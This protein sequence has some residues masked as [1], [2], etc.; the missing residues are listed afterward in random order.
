MDTASTTN[1]PHRRLRSKSFQKNLLL[2][3]GGIFLL[4]A[5][6][7][8]VYQYQRE[9]AYKIDILH[10]RLQMFNYEMVQTLGDSITNQPLFRDY[11]NLHK[12]E[13]LR[14]T[15]INNEG[16]VLLDSYETN[17]DSLSNHLGRTEIQG[18]LRDGNGYDIKRTSESTHE[19]YFYS[20]TKFSTPN[21]RNGTLIIRAAVPYSAELTQSLQADNTYIYF[22]IALTLLLG[23]ALY[24]STRRISRH[25]GYL[26]EFAVKAEEGEELDH[27]IERRLPD[28]EL[29]DISHTIIMLY[30]KLRHSE[31]DKVRIK[32]QLTQNAAHEL[33]TPAA[34]I[35][36]YLESI[37]DNPEMDSDKRQHF[38]ERCY[39]QSERMNKLL[40]DMSALTKLDEMEDKKASRQDYRQVNVLSVIHS[41]LDDTALQLQEKHIISSLEVPEQAEVF[42][43]QSLIYSIFR[44]LIDNV[45]SYATGATS[46]HIKCVEVEN[47]GLH[48]YEFTVSDNGPGVGPQHLQHLFERFYRVDKGRSRK[49]GGTGLGLA[50]V[51]NAVAA[52]GGTV[53][54]EITPG[55][56][57]TI[58][59]T[60]ARF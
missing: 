8:S 17:V 31:E 57:L 5:V 6:C 18:A 4:F 25:I 50:I 35:H 20:A 53:T 24:W 40:L 47:E 36:G 12:V 27:E 52:H 41:V 30:W 55:G 56:G 38:L 60:L 2:S 43:D 11:V 42:G 51:K 3:I 26:R 45:L 22:A 1:L 59:F 23:I 48:S 28:D 15:L 16:Q 29:G 7:F 49:L 33:K 46:V 13:G 32:R 58:R 39:A 44:N 54:A 10:S 21:H 34:S 14:V 37:L 9:K 19:T